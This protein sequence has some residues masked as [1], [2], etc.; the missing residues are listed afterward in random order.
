MGCRMKQKL[1]SRPDLDHLR[2]QAKS[3][4]ASLKGGDDG[5]ARTF[6]EHLP[7]AGKQTAAQVRNAGYRLADAQSAIARKTGFASWPALARHVTELRGLEGA[8]EFTS[9]EIE[10]S[11]MPKPTFG[12]SRLTI[13][14]DLFRMESPDATYEGVFN[15]D[16]EAKPPQI[17]IEFVQGPEAG[18]TSHGI[19][20]LGADALTICLGFTGAKRPTSFTTKPGTGHALE[21]LTRRRQ[22]A[23]EA[24]A[25]AVDFEPSP[26]QALAPIGGTWKA[27]SV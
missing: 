21:T 12:S 9:L 11:A 24:P 25:P 23:E 26:A 17:D 10:G 4:L 3:L 7:A 22:G 13:D 19:F 20:E 16:V 14:G 27:L 6:I 8:C 2:R 18:N 5:A 1:P 15:I